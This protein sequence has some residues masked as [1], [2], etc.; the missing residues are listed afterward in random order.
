LRVFLTGA[1]KGRASDEEGEK[2]GSAQRHDALQR[3]KHPAVVS[4]LKLASIA[5]TVSIGILT[6]H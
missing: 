1:E 2:N 3:R 5:S 4:G 6:L